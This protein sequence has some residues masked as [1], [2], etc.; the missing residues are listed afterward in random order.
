VVEQQGLRGLTLPRQAATFQPLAGGRQL[1]AHS[2]TSAPNLFD[3]KPKAIRAKAQSAPPGVVQR[4]LM[5][6]KEGYERRFHEPPVI[7]KRDGATIRILV[8]QFGADKVETR[9]RAFLNWDDQFI[10]D[11]GFALGM[12]HTSWNRLAARCIQQQ[13]ERR[14]EMSVDRTA[15]YLRSLRSAS[16][17]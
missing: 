6:Y 3:I 5:L 13:P 12:L 7:L 8:N 17:R 14:K 4:L 10:I 11:S 2:Q 15:E 16:A 9:L 1:V